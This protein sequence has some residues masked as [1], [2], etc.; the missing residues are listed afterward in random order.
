MVPSPQTALSGQKCD[1]DDN[2]ITMNHC[3]KQAEWEEVKLSLFA[4][5]TIQYTGNPRDAIKKY[6]NK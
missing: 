5:D 6:Q 3:Q 4:H 2:T 1:K